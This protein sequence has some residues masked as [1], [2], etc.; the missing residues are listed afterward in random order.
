VTFSPDKS[1]K[2]NTA[3][4]A[5]VTSDTTG[6]YVAELTPGTYN[7]S[8]K[9]TEGGTIVYTYAE[10]ISVVIGQDPISYTI[11]LIKESVTVMGSISYTD[12]GKANMTIFFSKDSRVKPNNAT[13]KS[14]MTDQYGKY[15]IELTPG[16]YNASIEELV[17]ESGLNVIYSATGQI[18]LNF[19]DTPK[20]LDMI[21]TRVES[22]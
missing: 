20:A 8:V 2:N 22:P 3:K 21:L 11:Y 12:V 4:Q 9:K 15:T 18:T 17:N 16:S 14:V 5:S 19:G 6:L 7:V 1:V 13:A 10:K